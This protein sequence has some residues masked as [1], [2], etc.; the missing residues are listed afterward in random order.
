[1]GTRQLSLFG[2]SVPVYVPGEDPAVKCRLRPM[3]LATPVAGML[4]DMGGVL[5]ED[6]AWRRWLLRLLHQMGL[7]THYRTFFRV[8]DREFLVHVQRGQC[9]FCDA[10][11]QFMRSVGLSRAMVDEVEAA[12]QARRRE[13]ETGIRALPGVKSTLLRLQQAGVVLGA[14]N[15]S[16]QTSSALVD[17]LERIGL[18]GLFVVVLSSIDLKRTKPDPVCYHTA[19]EAMNLPVS[20]V[21]FV[22]HDAE[23][24]AGATAV[25][26]QTVAFNFDPDAQA[27][28][29]IARFEELAEILTVRRGIAAAA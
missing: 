27:D 8:W 7:Y 14:L 29:F 26:M 23:E 18:A 22:G 5:Y 3:R 2:P 9:S 10:F 19:L 28:V 16:D 15:N 21:A 24:L 20:R 4:F 13:L 6:T 12:C 11:A 25:G 17:R 1:M